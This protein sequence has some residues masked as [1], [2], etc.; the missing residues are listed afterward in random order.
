M[1]QL[2]HK[3]EH[4]P[5]PSAG[6]QLA[7]VESS[8]PAALQQRDGERVSQCDCI[9]VE[10]VGARLCGQA[11]RRR[12]QGKDDVGGRPKRALCSRSHRDKANAKPA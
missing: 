12:W 3:R 6:M 11:S 7:K 9:S 5:E 10:V 1:H 4:G 8:E 2:T